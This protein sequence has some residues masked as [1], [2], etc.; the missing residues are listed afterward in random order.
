VVFSVRLL[1][2]ATGVLARNEVKIQRFLMSVKF[3]GIPVSQ[4]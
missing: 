2:D 1:P 4:D 3:K